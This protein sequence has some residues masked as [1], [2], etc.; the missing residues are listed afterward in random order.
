MG[1]EDAT[2]P[3]S[4]TE[5]ASISATCCSNPV[6]VTVFFVMVTMSRSIHGNHVPSI[7]YLEDARN[8]AATHRIEYP[9]RREPQII[10]GFMQII[11]DF[12]YHPP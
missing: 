2:C 3:P 4:F 7:H 12:A 9:F 5:N 6:V 10:S 8:N 1:V 11:Q